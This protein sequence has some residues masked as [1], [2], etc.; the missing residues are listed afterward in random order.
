[1]GLFGLL[2]NTNSLGS[3]SSTLVKLPYINEFFD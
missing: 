1:M 3:Y 2:T